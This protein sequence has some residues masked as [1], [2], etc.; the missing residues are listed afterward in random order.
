MVRRRS[1]ALRAVIKN[2]VFVAEITRQHQ[3]RFHPALDALLDMTSVGNYQMLIEN[4]IGVAENDEVVVINDTL[5]FIR[6]TIGTEK[7]APRLHRGLINGRRRAA[8]ALEVI[9]YED[10]GAIEIELLDLNFRERLVAFAQGLPVCFLL[11]NQGLNVSGKL[12]CT[13]RV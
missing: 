9:L 7:T 11:G 4:R 12:V 10:L 2:K 8:D 6:Q 3:D 5:L 13:L 1:T